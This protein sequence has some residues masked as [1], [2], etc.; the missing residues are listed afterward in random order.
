MHQGRCPVVGE[1]GVDGVGKHN[2]AV[3]KVDGLVGP[4]NP[5]LS[6]CSSVFIND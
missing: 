6:S 2:Q 1:H 4:K 5:K 3:C